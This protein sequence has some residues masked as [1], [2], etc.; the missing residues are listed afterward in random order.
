[1]LREII[2]ISSDFITIKIPDDLKNKEVELLILPFNEIMPAPNIVR[3][4]HLTTFKCQSLLRNFTR[5]DAYFEF[6]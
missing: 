3:K 5:E 4:L 2:K 1:M 6:I